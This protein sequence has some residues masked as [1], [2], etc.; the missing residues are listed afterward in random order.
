MH[1]NG[2][3]SQAE[4]KESIDSINEAVSK[5]MMFVI[6]AILSALFLL[7]G[8]ALFIA[9]GATASASTGFPVLI[10]VGLGVFFCGMIIM[11]IGCIV[12]QSQYVTRL[13]KAIAIES[14]KYSTRSKPCSWRMQTHR[15][16]SGINNNRRTVTTY[17]VSDIDCKE[18]SLTLVICV[19]CN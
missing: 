9:G 13:R 3:I 6:V 14:A 8:M 17:H 5:R 15:Y 19:D 18:T 2:F 7:G 16:V 12:N 4:F 10:G 1:L 11:V